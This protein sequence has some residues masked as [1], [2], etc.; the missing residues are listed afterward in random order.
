MYYNLGNA[1]YRLKDVPNS[2]LYY[3]RAKLLAPGD[4]DI[5]FN[6]NVANLRTVDKIN[7][8][9]EFFLTAW[10]NGLR[11]SFPSK[12]WAIITIIFSW[13]T[14]ISLALFF[15]FWKP[16]SRKIL[17]ALAVIF[18]IINIFSFIFA[19]QSY[20]KETSR[21]Y[22]IIFA[23]SVFMKSSPDENST[24]L[25]SLHEGT[26]VKILDEVVNWKKIRL[27]DGN[28]GWLPDSAIEII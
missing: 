13:L 25:V 3:E 7:K 17:F 4:E 2:I 18:L 19:H 5:N 12:T 14:F 21:D 1:Y 11:D 8:V 6:L 24:K 15:I 10:F 20:K 23:P 16:F 22:A 27:A 9:P 26:K 28:V